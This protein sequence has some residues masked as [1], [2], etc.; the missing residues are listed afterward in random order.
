M[1]ERILNFNLIANKRVQIVFVGIFLLS[2]FLQTV[3][4]MKNNSATYD[5]IAHLP[6]GYSYLKTGDFR[7]NQEHPPLIKQLCALPLLFLNLDFPVNREAWNA[8]DQWKYGLSFLYNNRIDA[9]KILFIGRI[10]VVILSCV[11]GLLLFLWTKQLFG[12]EAGLFSLFLYAFCPNIIAH[13]SL[14]TMDLGITL[15]TFLSLYTFWRFLKEPGWSNS[16]FCGITIGL[17]L[18]AKF[19]GLL[20]FPIYLVIGLIFYLKEGKLKINFRMIFL[21][22]GISLFIV[23]AVYKFTSIGSYVDGFKEM[24]KYNEGFQTFLTGQY[25]IT[26]WHHYFLVAFLLKTPIP[27]LLFILW[28]L[29]L[30]R[31]NK[32]IY[33]IYIPIIFFFLFFSFSKRQQGLRYILPIYPLLFL[34][35]GNVINFVLKR[36]KLLVAFFILC[37]WCVF[38]QIKIF[39]H[40]LAYFNEFVGGPNNG[41]RYLSDCNI[42]WGQD[43]KR[44]GTFLKKEEVSDVIL[45]YF[46]TPPP[47]YYI[48]K[49]QNLM[50]SPFIDYRGATVNSLVPKKEYL[51]VSA[52]QLTGVYFADHSVLSWL[53]KYKPVKKIGYSIFVYDITDSVWTHLNIGQIYERYGEQVLAQREYTRAKIIYNNIK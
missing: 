38:S 1:K 26:G 15:F 25:G 13:S 22:V 11:L 20:L 27:S 23:A 3:L 49:F 4:S 21:A 6:A 48:P 41:W 8:S 14:V 47:G 40:Y 32:S 17:A 12:P 43:L 50:S 39:P 35:A 9:D 44:L 33:F 2:I 52:T 16:I 29:W 53:W 5:E 7:M 28:G 18:A 45:C 46:G 30:C 36:R 19:S 51:A 37:G 34:C 42:D 31:K 10:S 24:S